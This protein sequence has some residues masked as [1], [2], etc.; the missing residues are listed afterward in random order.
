MNKSTRSYSS[1]SD[2]ARNR[3]EHSTQGNSLGSVTSKISK[4]IMQQ[5][6]GT[7]DTDKPRRVKTL[8]EKKKMLKLRSNYARNRVVSFDSIHLPFDIDGICQ[9]DAQLK[10]EIDCIMALRP[11]RFFWVLDEAPVIEEVILPPPTTSEET[12]VQELEAAVADL[13]EEETVEEELTPKKKTPKSRAGKP[14]K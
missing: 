11:G 7:S 8:E 5:A 6:V 10:A 9:V 3:V 14:A 1:T 13:V 2:L 12:L 4:S